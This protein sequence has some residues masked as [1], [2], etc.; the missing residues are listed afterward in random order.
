M[1]ILTLVQKVTQSYEDALQTAKNAKYKPDQEAASLKA[2]IDVLKSS[3]FFEVDGDFEQ[4]AVELMMDAHGIVPNPNAEI[5][6]T[7][8]AF[9][10][11]ENL[12]MPAPISAVY[13]PQRDLEFLTVCV[14]TQAA[15][16]NLIQVPSK[17]KNE[18]VVVM[19]FSPNSLPTIV[20]CWSRDD[21]TLSLSEE[22]SKHGKMTEELKLQSLFMMQ[23][24]VAMFD[25]MC[26]PTLTVS[27]PVGSR[28]SRRYMQRTVGIPSERWSK[29]E[30][31][32]GEKIKSEIRKNDPDNCKPLHF[33]RG[34]YR[35]AKEH[36]KNAVQV[37]GVWHQWI[38]GFW[39]GHPA[40][41][42]VRSVHAPKYAA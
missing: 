14:E 32:V 26:K 3:Q 21:G 22:I 8:K 10:I 15:N 20:G 9:K 5:H 28:Q 17:L 39:C 31:N 27:A 7:E 33:R 38:E 13:M 30:W 40:F 36:F 41:G 2:A 4:T 1:D 25:L 24:L 35:K 18:D 23:T 37:D 34:H 11:P 29:I 6:Q 19:V 16:K 12:K 42:F